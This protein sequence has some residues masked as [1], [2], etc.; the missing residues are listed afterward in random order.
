[1]PANG[2][3]DPNYAEDCVVVFNPIVGSNKGSIELN[4][5]ILGVK[6]IFVSVQRYTGYNTRYRIAELS[7]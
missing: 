5:N 1:M 7:L 3:I 6:R 4:V 2:Q